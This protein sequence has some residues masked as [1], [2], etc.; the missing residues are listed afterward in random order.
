MVS[1]SS[2]HQKDTCVTVL[3][4]YSSTT[5]GVDKVLIITAHLIYAGKTRSLS[6]A[7]AAVDAPVPAILRAGHPLRLGDHFRWARL[8][9]RWWTRWCWCCTGGQGATGELGRRAVS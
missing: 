4:D 1:S 6:S 9:T 7:V 8:W 5:L 3:P 2:L